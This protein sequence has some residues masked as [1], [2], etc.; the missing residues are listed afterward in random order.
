MS[1]VLFSEYI[2]ANV[3]DNMARPLSE[4]IKAA[5]AKLV[6]SPLQASKDVR[7]A[8]AFRRVIAMAA[9]IG[10][11]IDPMSEKKLSIVQV[12]KALKESGASIEERFEIKTFL[13]AAQLL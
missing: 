9:R 3:K 7:L 1:K 8:P 12:D 6:V 13:A 5:A 10:L 11:E 2:R 4:E